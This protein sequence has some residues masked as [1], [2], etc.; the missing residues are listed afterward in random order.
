[1]S[2]ATT[3]KAFTSDLEFKDFEKVASYLADNFAAEGLEAQKLDKDGFI[4]LQKALIE[5]FPNLRFHLHS[6]EEHGNRVLGKVQITGTHSGDLV[7]PGMAPVPATGK[8]ISL[9][10]EELTFYFEGEKIV[11]LATNNVAG[12]GVA[13]ILQQIEA[14]SPQG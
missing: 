10:E 13:G 4:A 3:V 12:G 6:T 14:Q 1:M 7:L 11:S 9:P 5:A 2:A 8:T